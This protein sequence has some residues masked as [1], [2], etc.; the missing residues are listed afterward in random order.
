LTQD[1]GWLKNVLSHTS[2]G[3]WIE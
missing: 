3:I 1:L 2:D